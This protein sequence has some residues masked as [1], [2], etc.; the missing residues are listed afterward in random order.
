MI[1]LLLWHALYLYIATYA[2]LIA[3]AV[4]HWIGTGPRPC[5]VRSEGGRRA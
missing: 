1:R 4:W 3:Y 2:L 5:P